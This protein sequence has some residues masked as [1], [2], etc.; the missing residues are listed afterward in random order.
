MREG[1]ARLSKRLEEL[2]AFDAGKMWVES[3]PEL[4]VLETAIERALAKTFGDD[5]PDFRRFRTAASLRWSPMAYIGGQ[6]TPL[7]DYQNAVGKKVEA[8]RALLGEAIRTLQEDIAEEAERDDQTAIV[9][10]QTISSNKVF[11]VHGHDDGAKEQL[12]RWLEKLGLET[13]IL[14]EQP[15]QGRTIIE[16][17]EAY[18][19]QVGF[20]VVL[21]T[22]DDIGAAKADAGQ[23][24]RARQ[25]V[26]F[27]LG[28]F[29]G[30]LGR[31]KTC[32]LRKGDV[33]I[34][35]D[36]YGVIYSEL[37][38]NEGWKMKLV[39]E[40]KAAGVDFDANKAWE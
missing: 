40:M 16:K 2:N 22:P 21:L 8:S 23:H 25:N 13:I 30:K 11:V 17:F 10:V 38:A 14:H 5:T 29:A 27:E 9:G 24:F 28:F 32:L 18:A 31:G 15:D 1:V 3:P 6:R 19:G 12:A 35:S 37:D 26:I 36:L 33:E 39:K 7:S 4:K 20:A 34:P